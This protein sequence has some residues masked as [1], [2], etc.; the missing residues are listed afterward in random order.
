MNLLIWNSNRTTSKEF[1]CTIKELLRI[2]KPVILGLLE[3]KVSG[4]KADTICNKL[5]FEHWLRVE[6]LG[7]SGGI[8]LLWKESCNVQI[9]KTHPQF[10]HLKVYSEDDQQWLLSVVYGSPTY[11]LR[12]FLWNDLNGNSLDLKNPWMVAG[13][14]NSVM[15]ASKVSNP[16]KLDQK[17]CSAFNDWIFYHE[18]IDMGFSGPCFT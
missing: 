16:R 18:L 17:R 6:A 11:S 13:G 9:L 1:S 14:F 2:H 5:G 4:F 15:K 8:W 7:F 10:I 3:T 12:K